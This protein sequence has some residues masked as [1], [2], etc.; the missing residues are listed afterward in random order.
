LSTPA[1][2]R[3]ADWRTEEITAILDEAMSAASFNRCTGSVDSAGTLGRGATRHASWH[4]SA[5]HGTDRAHRCRA[6]RS[7]HF[8]LHLAYAG[9]MTGLDGCRNNSDQSDYTSGH[10]TQRPAETLT[11]PTRPPMR[12]EY[13]LYEAKA[14]LSALVRQVREGRSVI[15]TVHGVPAAVLR[16]IDAE[17]RPQTIEE[18]L[19]E[20]ESRGQL[21]PARL[22]ATH[23]DAFPVGKKAPGAL[24][25]FLEERD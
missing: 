7:P 6:R 10:C 20:L 21:I 14:R 5:K 1:V 12:D 17:S 11:I 18:R 2:D 4:W 25:R 24:K 9:R 15:I 16:P 8:R 19:A 23:P 13:S 3:V 22:S